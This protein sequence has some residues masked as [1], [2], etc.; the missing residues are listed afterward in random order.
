EMNNV[1]LT[2]EEYGRLKAKYPDSDNLIERLSLYLASTGKSYNSHYATLLRWAEEEKTKQP[3]PKDE[4]CNDSYDI[5][6][7]FEAALRHSREKILGHSV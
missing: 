2:E 1:I 4:S 3:P 5:D 6:E 7:F